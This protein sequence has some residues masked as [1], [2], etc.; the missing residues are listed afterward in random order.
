MITINKLIDLERFGIFYLTGEADNLAYRALCDV[1]S[2]G[3]DLLKEVYG[4]TA[5]SPPANSNT[6]G[7][8]HVASVMLSYRAWQDIGPI[9]LTVH[10]GWQLG[11]GNVGARCHTVFSVKDGTIYGIQSNELFKQAEYDWKADPTRPCNQQPPLLKAAEFSTDNGK[12]WRLWP[13]CY[14]ELDRMFSQAKSQPHV[15]SRNIH[16]ISGQTFG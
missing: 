3:R 1:S 9:G 16:A 13:T 15:G 12:T 11:L 2:R 4:M 14:G 5:D 6:N 8:K 7:E 10:R